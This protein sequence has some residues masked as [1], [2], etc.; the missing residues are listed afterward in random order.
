VAGGLKASEWVAAALAPSGG[1]SGGKDDQA[2][3]TSKEVGTVD[4]VLA[5]AKAYAAGRY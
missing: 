1:R 5:A 3:G 2:Q 4:A